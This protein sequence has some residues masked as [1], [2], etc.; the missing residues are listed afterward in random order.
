MVAVVSPDLDCYLLYANE[1]FG[2]VLGFPPPCLVGGRT[3][4]YV[5]GAGQEEEDL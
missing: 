3:N 4:S 2:H 5:I 1:A